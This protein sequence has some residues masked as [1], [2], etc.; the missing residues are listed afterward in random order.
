V[1]NEFGFRKGITTEDNIFKIANK[2]L[3]ALN[4]NTNAGSILCDLE[5]AFNSVNHHSLLSE[6]PHYGISGRAK[7]LLQSYIHNRLQKVTPFN[8]D[9]NLVCYL[10][11]F[12]GAHHIIYVSRIRVKII[13]VYVTS[14]TSQNGPK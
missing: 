4:N 3:N 14:N 12:L 7:L 2:N 8:A 5:R 10:L 11:V 6:L 1:G 9:L 13:N